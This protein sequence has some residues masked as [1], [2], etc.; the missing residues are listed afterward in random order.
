M[1]RRRSS[2]RPVPS[3]RSRRNDIDLLLLPEFW[4]HMLRPHLSV[5]ARTRCRLLSRWHAA[6]DSE[7]LI[8]RWAVDFFAEE[9]LTIT[10]LPLRD[11][12]VAHG[13]PTECPVTS[14]NGHWLFVCWDVDDRCLIRCWLEKPWAPHHSA[15]DIDYYY[16]Y[17]WFVAINFAGKTSYFPS[18]T[19]DI[20]ETASIRQLPVR[21]LVRSLK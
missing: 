14:D 15:Y 12:F 4:T 21:D 7:D 10:T 16:S 19:M 17:S 2:H 18:N 3:K 9:G 6:L 1:K 13:F 8:P 20:H 5:F 11:F